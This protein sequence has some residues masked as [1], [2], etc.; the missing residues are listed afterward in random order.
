MFIWGHG[1]EEF[2]NRLV[3]NGVR[4]IKSANSR[5]YKVEGATIKI[6]PDVKGWTK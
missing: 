2:E 4:P 3:A 5:I 6:T 1:E